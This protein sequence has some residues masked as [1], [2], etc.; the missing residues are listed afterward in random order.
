[1][2][3]LFTD[4]KPKI[5]ASIQKAMISEEVYVALLMEEVI[6]EIKK[7]NKPNYMLYATSGGMPGRQKHKKDPT[8]ISGA[9]SREMFQALNQISSDATYDAASD[10]ALGS[11]D[12]FNV[13]LTRR[14][15]KIHIHATLKNKQELFSNLIEDNGGSLF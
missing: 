13:S 3:G 2:F 14:F 11:V 12:R 15:G 8:I 10:Y 6:D 9:S 5:I 4:N 7:G 1:M